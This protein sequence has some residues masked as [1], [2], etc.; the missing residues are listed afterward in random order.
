VRRCA[1]SLAAA[2]AVVVALA[3]CASSAPSSPPGAARA[4]ATATPPP[5]APEPSAA[6]VWGLD[7]A[8]RAARRL[9]Q[10]TEVAAATVLGRGVVLLRVT[11]DDR[12][13][14]VQRV[15]SGYAIPLDA[16]AVNPRRYARTVPGDAQAAFAGLRRGTIVISQTESRLRRVGVGATF[17]LADGRRA[18]V[19]AVVDDAVLRNAEVAVAEGDPRVP[20]LR[21]TVIVALRAPASR[22]QLIRWT[23]RGAA[24][25]ILP[26][27][28]LPASGPVGPAR[29][30]QLKIRFGEP[31]VGL[32]YGSDWIRIAPGFLSRHIVH[33]R[34][35]IL[36]TVTC[37][38]AMVGHLRAALGELA[39]RGL[40]GLVDPG[41]YAGCY[42]PRRIQP[43]GQLSLHAWGLAV[44][45]NASRNPFRGRSRQDRR[46]VRI[47][48]KHGF[49]WGGRWPT[50]PDPMHFEYRG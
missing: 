33:R 37:H 27:G 42:A 36:G 35:P 21:T 10:R 8:E 3:G 49:T 15:R 2:V 17:D 24:A 32:P 9:R 34:V 4:I 30:G 13:R 12:G 28:P 26:G 5:A 39:D 7:D 29:P 18:R 14:V 11:R 1:P 48:E 16:I 43:R 31:A 47:M 25:R 6:L 40:S 46:L 41:D 20:P 45:L 44:D 50:R 23:E 19:A 22:R 38:R